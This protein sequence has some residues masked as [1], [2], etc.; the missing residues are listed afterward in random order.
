[1]IG[2]IERTKSYQL[3]GSLYKIQEILLDLKYYGKLHPLIKEVTLVSKKNKVAQFY[4]IKEKPFPKIPINISY[5]ALVTQT[6]EEEIVY[7]IRDLPLTKAA[8]KYT[9]KQLEHN[10]VDIKFDLTIKNHL[11]GKKILAKKMLAA[12]DE[13]MKAMQ[14]ELKKI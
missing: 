9:L 13:L 8:I 6:P 4:K 14:K 10:K 12:Q 5:T 1:M 3:S 2:Q 7:M 11:I